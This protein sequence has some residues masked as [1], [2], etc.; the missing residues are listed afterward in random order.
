MRAGARERRRLEV[1]LHPALVARSRRE[2]VVL[3]ARLA[4]GRAPAVGGAPNV[5]LQRERQQP[6]SDRRAHLAY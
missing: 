3:R 6:A 5:P 2:G 4:I 1:D